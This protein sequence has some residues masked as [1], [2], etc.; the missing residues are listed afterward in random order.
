MP[1]QLSVSK[2]QVQSESVAMMKDILAAR[3][4]ILI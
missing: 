4:S 2:A 3:S 1:E